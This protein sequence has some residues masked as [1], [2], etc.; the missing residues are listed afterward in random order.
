MNAGYIALLHY[1]FSYYHSN[2]SGSGWINWQTHRSKLDWEGQDISPGVTE[3]MGQVEQEVD[4]STAGSSQICSWEKDTDE[5]ALHDSGYTEHQQE[6]EDHWWVAISQ[7]FPVL[8]TETQV[9]KCKNDI[10]Y[11][12]SHICLYYRSIN[13]KTMNARVEAAEPLKRSS[14]RIIHPRGSAFLEMKVCTCWTHISWH[15]NDKA[16][17]ACHN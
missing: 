5:E 13:M 14:I 11:A 8:Q 1:H 16:F 4:K 17:S 12:H 10:L 9:Q 7:N 2:N 3:H 15:T 6:H